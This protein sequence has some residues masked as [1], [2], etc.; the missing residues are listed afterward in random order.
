MT[1]LMTLTKKTPIIVQGITGKQGSFHTERMLEYGSNIVAGV[2]PGKG[3]TTFGKI[4]VFNSVKEAIVATKAEWSVIF[5]PAAYAKAAALESLENNLHTVVITENIPVLDS[6]E[7]VTLAKKKK[8]ILIGPNC[9]GI[10]VPGQAKLGIMPGHIFSAGSVGLVSRSGT[11][12]YEVIDQLTKARIGQ[13][14]VLGIGGD[15]IIGTNFVEALEIFN[16]DPKTKHIVL[17]GEIG[18][19]AEE[20]AAVYIKKYVKKP[21]VAYITGRTAPKGKRMGHAGA[22]ISG[23]SG[24]AEAKIQA[25]ADAK[26]P[27]AELP[28]DIVKLLQKMTSKN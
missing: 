7:F 26:V 6:L 24:T 21:V 27:V 1:E 18:G 19:D 3:G 13:S 28:S 4:P 25:F 22:V 12:T 15:P 23:S 17:I 16:N 5:V 11:L 2:T 8:R 20:R 14:K 10:M 9:P